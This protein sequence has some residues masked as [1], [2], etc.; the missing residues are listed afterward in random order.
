MNTKKLIVGMFVVLGMVGMSLG[1]SKH[2]ASANNNDGNSDGRGEQ[3]NEAHA[4]GSTLEVHINDNGTVLV[5]GAKVT[6]VS[7]TVVSA[8]TAWASSSMNWQVTTDGSTRFMNH[9][10]S[11]NSNKISSVTVGDF[12]SFTGSIATGT[13]GNFTVTGSIIKDWSSQTPVNVKTT[14]EGKVKAVAVGGV[15]TSFTLTVGQKDYTV[16]VATDT[17][18]L[19]TQWLRASLAN[20]SAGD[21]VRVYGMVNADMTI[22]ATVV[23][24][25]NLQ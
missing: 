17:S 15:P 14:V 2:Y 4:T 9:F 20:I 11:E 21:T 22:D 25:V 3:I 24:D 18:L 13:N 16:R 12:I 6:S 7:G 10:G 8:T 5:R 1:V 23:R 19:N